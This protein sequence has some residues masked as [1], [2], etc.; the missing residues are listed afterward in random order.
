[1]TPIYP[2]T[3]FNIEEK[4]T[5]ISSFDLGNNIELPKLP[6]GVGDRW[7]PN[8]MQR[9][10]GKEVFDGTK[11]WTR[12]TYGYET[13]E[14]QTISF[15]CSDNILENARVVTTDTD[16]AISTHLPQR[17]SSTGDIG[18]DREYFF[19]SSVNR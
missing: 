2:T 14:W 16:T 8:S 6:N 1:R 17:G 4:I 18:N 9:N 5:R 10:V 19:I 11:I 3:E 12:Y 15:Q 13:S 7:Y